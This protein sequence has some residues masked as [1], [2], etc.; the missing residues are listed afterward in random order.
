[1][2]SQSFRSIAPIDADS[3]LNARNNLFQPAKVNS[4]LRN[5]NVRHAVDSGNLYEPERE[6][7]YHSFGMDSPLFESSVVVNDLSEFEYDDASDKSNNEVVVETG[8]DSN[9]N[10][11]TVHI[12]ESSLI[13]ENEANAVDKH[14]PWEGSELKDLFSPL[15]LEQ[16]FEDPPQQPSVADEPENSV[17][18]KN[19]DLSHVGSFMAGRDFDISVVVQSESDS[20]GERPLVVRPKSAIPVVKATE[21]PTFGS[22]SAKYSFSPDPSSTIRRNNSRL[23]KSRRL[24]LPLTEQH[25]DHSSTWTSSSRNKSSVQLFQLHY[26]TATKDRLH[27]LVSELDKVDYTNVPAIEDDLGVDVAIKRLKLSDSHVIDLAEPSSVIEDAT[28]AVAVNDLPPNESSLDKEIAAFVADEIKLDQMKNCDRRRYIGIDPVPL[29]PT[30]DIKSVVAVTPESLRENAKVTSKNEFTVVAPQDENQDVT[31]VNIDEMGLLSL[32]GVSSGVMNLSAAGNQ[33]CSECSFDAFIHL[34]TLQLDGNAISDLCIFSK[35]IHLR[36]LMLDNNCLESFKGLALM[37]SLVML[38][39]K[40]NKIVNFENCS[41]TT[42]E[43]LFVSNNQI[44]YLTGLEKMPRLTELDASHNQI[45][46]IEMKVPHQVL[47][48]LNL[49]HNRLKYFSL[50]SFPALRDLN[51]DENSIANIDFGP[52]SDHQIQSLRIGRQVSWAVLNFDCSKF[53]ML[54]HL[55]LADM[56]LRDMSALLNAK[57]LKHLDAIGCHIRNIPEKLSRRLRNLQHLDLSNNMLTNIDRLS[58]HGLLK[59]LILY[60]NEIKLLADAASVLTSMKELAVVDLRMN[61][62]TA[63]F[64]SSNGGDCDYLTTLN[65][66][67]FIKRMCYRSTLICGIQAIIRLDGL[68]ITRKDRRQAQ[69]QYARLKGKF[70]ALI[71]PCNIEKVDSPHQIRTTVT[72]SEE[73]SHRLL[74]R[75]GSSVCFWIPTTSTNVKRPPTLSSS[76]AASVHPMKNSNKP[77]VALK[78]YHKRS[79]STYLAYSAEGGKMILKN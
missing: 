32:N 60:G 71:P 19:I 30:I 23:E 24:K 4:P 29:P 1:M 21:T 63:K 69:H 13:A 44:E 73:Q 9:V 54:T 78:S 51:I 70:S 40:A 38:S 66:V 20:D 72:S 25:H 31:T 14:R 58:G 35:L 62:V 68:E 12:R 34:Q 39:L 37:K 6:T 61:P 57:S 77:A 43:R 59:S 79:E 75:S 52:V 26:D 53:T 46:T 2:D 18:F 48:T 22:P 33:L 45:G 27:A 10:Y 47:N 64:Y 49:V 28:Q 65:D 67:T 7:E 15:K 76:S 16:M 17:Q 3:F 11:D 74:K 42:L 50:V 56:M 5:Q 36:D 41:S 8:V 55:S